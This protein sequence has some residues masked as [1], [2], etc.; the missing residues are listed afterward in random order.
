MNQI[1]GKMKENLKLQNA[2]ILKLIDI[3]RQNLAFFTYSS[4][5]VGIQNFIEIEVVMSTAVLI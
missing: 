1:V 3:G 2:V 5:S 4:A